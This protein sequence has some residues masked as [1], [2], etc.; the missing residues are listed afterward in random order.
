MEWWEVGGAAR[1]VFFAKYNK[2]N[3]IEEDEVGGACGTNGEEEH[4]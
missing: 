1:L 2:I 4:E 3:Q